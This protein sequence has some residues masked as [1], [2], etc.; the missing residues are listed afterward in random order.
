MHCADGP[1]QPL[2]YLRKGGPDRK[3]GERDPGGPRR[4]SVRTLDA[5]KVCTGMFQLSSL[6]RSSLAALLQQMLVPLLQCEQVGDHVAAAI[7]W[8]SL[9]LPQ[10]LRL[11]LAQRFLAIRNEG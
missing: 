6:H 2:R 8:H 3:S 7:L 5:S 11:K 1:A 9:G 10:Y 4:G